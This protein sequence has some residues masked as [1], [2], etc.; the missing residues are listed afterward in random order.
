VSSTNFRALFLL[1][2]PLPSLTSQMS[3]N[4]SYIC[5][6]RRDVK[7][8]RRASQGSPSEKLS[9]LKQVL[10][11]AAKLVS[12]VLKLEPKWLSRRKMCGKNAGTI[13][14][15]SGSFPRYSILKRTTS[16]CVTKRGWSKAQ[17]SRTIN[18]THIPIIC[19]CEFINVQSFTA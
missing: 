6:R 11:T 16:C 3:K 8:M 9:R 7:A 17:A 18:G 13:P 4:E 5:F 12:G 2:F 15:S 14:T 19:E 10:T 1:R